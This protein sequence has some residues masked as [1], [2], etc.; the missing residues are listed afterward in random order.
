MGRRLLRELDRDTDLIRVKGLPARLVVETGEVE[1]RSLPR[2][3]E[4]PRRS[5]GVENRR[6]VY[7]IGIARSYVWFSEMTE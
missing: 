2:G 4:V 3:L 5:V 7:R 1:V 6:V